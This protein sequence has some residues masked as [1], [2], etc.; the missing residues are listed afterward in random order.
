MLTRA[1][2]LSNVLV[3]EEGMHAAF[4]LAK[5]SQAPVN[6]QGIPQLMLGSFEGE[7]FLGATQRS[8]GPYVVLR[9]LSGVWP[10]AVGDPL[11]LSDALEARS[12]QARL[13]FFLLYLLGVAGLLWRW[14]TVCVQSPSWRWWVFGGLLFYGL[15]TCLLY[16]SPSPRDATLSR[17]PS[18]A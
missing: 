13:P 18:S 10:V 8:I 12:V 4:V 17:M 14:A 3:G 6:E 5:G 9:W 2:F 11:P 16:T 1:P 7:A 15:T